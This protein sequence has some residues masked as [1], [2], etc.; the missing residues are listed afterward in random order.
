ME[1]LLTLGRGIC[2]CLSPVGVGTDWMGGEGGM[3]QG[4]FYN[5]IA[6]VT[7]ALLLSMSE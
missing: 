6:T 5:L 4:P 1:G 2:T 7:L 3:S